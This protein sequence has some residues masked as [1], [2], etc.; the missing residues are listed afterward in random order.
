M[1]E[2]YRTIEGLGGDVA[3]TPYIFPMI[4]AA[5]K[6]LYGAAVG[7]QQFQDALPE[8]F[9]REI[10]NSG[11]VKAMEPALNKGVLAP[12]TADRITRFQNW[13]KR[14]YI[15]VY[16]EQAYK[17][18]HTSPMYTYDD[19]GNL[20]Y[21]RDDNGVIK[22]MEVPLPRSAAAAILELSHN[23]LPFI[24]K[25][26]KFFLEQAPFT[27]G[28]LLKAGAVGKKNVN[29]IAKARTDSPDDYPPPIVTGKRKF[30]VG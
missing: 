28:I 13:Y 5:A 27:G 15:R 2:Y 1:G 11:L 29:R 20:T 25:A 16:G 22:T 8:I 7:E 17:E 26:G 4:G 10:A 6:A 14:N 30:V 23:E 3:R 18:D 24:H 19:Q 21:D 9:N 12:I